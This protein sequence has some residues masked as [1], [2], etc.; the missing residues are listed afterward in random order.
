MVVRRL[1]HG[2][3]RRQ[4]FSFVL[5]GTRH[6]N[7]T[8][9]CTTASQPRLLLCPGGYSALQARLPSNLCSD[10]RKSEPPPLSDSADFSFVLEGYSALQAQQA[11]P[12]LHRQTSPLSWRV[13]STPSPRNCSVLKAFSPESKKILLSQTLK[14]PRIVHTHRQTFLVHT[15]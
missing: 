4:G 6:S 7:P 12:L 13:L 15:C 1:V 9:D 2:L 11:A 10:L 3:P 8:A 14:A 5:E